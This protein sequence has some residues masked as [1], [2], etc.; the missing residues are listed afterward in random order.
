MNDKKRLCELIRGI[1]AKFR[2]DNDLYNYSHVVVKLQGSQKYKRDAKLRAVAESRGLNAICEEEVRHFNPR[3]MSSQG[4]LFTPE[5]LTCQRLDQI[6]W[7]KLSDAERDIIERLEQLG[8]CT[9]QTET[10]GAVSLITASSNAI[11]EG[12][13]LRVKMMKTETEQIE[14]LNIL[15]G[16]RA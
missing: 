4:W 15:E 14:L 3:K 11:A 9:L 2:A 5:M 8:L 13:G 16:L 6:A 7:N 10:F 1:I 12:K